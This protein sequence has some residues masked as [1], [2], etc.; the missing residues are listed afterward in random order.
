M[1]R[2]E[3][4]RIAVL[5]EI[6]ILHETARRDPGGSVTLWA[7]A[8]E[9][10]EAGDAIWPLDIP[11]D[12]RSAARQVAERI[13][14]EMAGWVGTRRPLAARGRAVRPDDVLILVQS[15]SSLFHELI[16]ACTGPGWATPGA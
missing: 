16:R 4:R 9:E 11:K 6:T 14:G 10:E 2:D 13:A 12:T 7:P 1:F 15:R 8:R 5:E 3:A